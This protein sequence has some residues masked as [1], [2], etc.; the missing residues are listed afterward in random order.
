MA[1]SSTSPTSPSKTASA[2]KTTARDASVDKNQT[3]NAISN[4]IKPPAATRS[5]L[6]KPATKPVVVK[7]VIKKTPLSAPA[8]VSTKTKA[9]TKKAP[10]KKAASKKTTAKKTTPKKPATKKPVAKKTTAKKLT[11]Q[12][13]L[14]QLEARLKRANATTRKNVKTLE[15]LVQSLQSQSTKAQTTQK[16]A[17]TQQVNALNAKLTGLM[18]DSHAEIAKDLSAAMTAPRK[19]E[20]DTFNSLEAAMMRADDRLARTEIAQAEAITKINR[21]LANLAS[22]LETRFEDE[23]AK[24]TAA[25]EASERK[26][27]G[28]IDEKLADFAK[29]NTTDGL[30]R[31]IDT[32]ETDTAAALETL[33]G[34]IENFA[35]EL[36]QRQ[37]RI[38]SQMGEKVSEIALQTQ[39]EFETFRSHM[40][41][42]LAQLS[43]QEQPRLDVQ[44]HV[45]QDRLDNLEQYIAD[46]KFQASSGNPLGNPL[47]ST[48]QLAPTLPSHTNM[49]AP[50]APMPS[51]VVPIN[52]AFAPTLTPNN[53][54]ASAATTVPESVAPQALTP[55]PTIPKP[56]H[57]A[58]IPVE[59]DP[60]AYQNTTAATPNVSPAL[61]PSEF[62]APNAIPPNTIP[63]PQPIPHH[64]AIPAPIAPAP[65]VA[66]P[67]TTAP[68]PMGAS[69]EYNMPDLSV[70]DLSAPDLSEAYTSLTDLPDL[71]DLA[72]P[73]AA[74]H[75]NRD[76]EEPALPYADPAYAEHDNPLR[77][78][79]IGQPLGGPVNKKRS[80]PKLDLSKS[81]IKAAPLKFLL[82]GSAIAVLALFAGKMVLGGGD[83][84]APVP[85]TPAAVSQAPVNQFGQNPAISPAA[86]SPETTNSTLGN[87]ALGNATTAP[88][89]QYAEN[90]TPN[91]ST[92]DTSTL[93]GA[94]ESGN[95]IAQYQLGLTHL[96]ASATNPAELEDA[97]KF[98]RAAAA[99]NMPAA[100]YRLAKLY[101][102]GQGVNLDAEQ[103]R[104]L[105]E[106]AAKSGHRIAMHDLALYY[107]DVDVAV[108]EGW[109]A[110]AAQH[111]VVDSQ[112][113]LAV[114]SES[115]NGPDRDVDKAFFWYNIAAKQGDQIA[116]QRIEAISK[117]L[118]PEQISAAQ[119]RIAA[120]IPR[121]VNPEVNGV[122]R[123]LPW[124]T[125]AI[126]SV[127]IEQIRQA[128][129]YL[130]E[131][132]YEVGSPDGAMGPRT[133]AAITEFEKANA[134]P[135]TGAVNESLLDQ[136]ELA[137][138]A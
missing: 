23:T 36:D 55:Q 127:R 68:P 42:R 128:Q 134:L 46:M 69:G 50:E 66:T 116:Q 117:D 19:G 65:I 70:P 58:H 122:F 18:Q 39:T 92:T 129:S 16:A 64:P 1:A 89:G 84:Y 4:N 5:K 56:P 6:K 132:G 24:R 13:Q 100:Q 43:S 51:N 125:N 87:A 17:F 115:K 12:A 86:T 136:L 41:D 88:I 108:A 22:V 54:Y 53:P 61:V 111:G 31:K 3:P 138:G 60:A 101:E 99:Q 71:T 124:Q 98:I 25:I 57:E 85:A 73:A 48:A 96:Q 34:K 59:F 95:P 120:F 30:T 15:Q 112:F 106:R 81:P 63:A 83:K 49:P 38:D 90:V 113:N 35:V 133:R 107:V 137:V 2:S 77:A 21:H 72:E 40:D 131:L 7:A 93:K 110:Q 47:H 62:M 27:G 29:A 91:I 97:V 109:F 118:S 10:V 32:I 114:L 79:R 78:E 104:Q 126:K 67:V 8:N 123:D 135:E 45:L 44:M 20:V 11:V 80:L 33:G 37:S 14:T 121:P 28:Q 26:L 52:D 119:A 82:I 105:T 9:A 94:A 74:P 75:L 103:A 102:T 76:Y 130:A